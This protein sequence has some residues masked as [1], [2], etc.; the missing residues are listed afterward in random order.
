[1]ERRIKF[2]YGLT[3]C[4]IVAYTL[5][6]GYWLYSRYQLSL[7]EY[8]SELYDTII[9]CFEEDIAVRKALPSSPRLYGNRFRKA[10]NQK[11]DDKTEAWTCEIIAFDTLHHSLVIPK[12]VD[13]PTYLLEF[14]A[15]HGD[16]QQSE[17]PDG[18]ERFEFTCEN[19]EGVG[20]DLLLEALDRFIVDLQHPFQ[21]E[22]LDSI[23]RSRD[24]HDDLATVH[25]NRWLHLATLHACVVS[26]RHLRGAGGC[27]DNGHQYFASHPS[28]GL[29]ITNADIAIVH[30]YLLS[31]LSDTDYPKATAH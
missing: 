6:Q 7:D 2:I 18:M 12:D 3:I 1:M 26:L 29:Y 23:L 30:P 22:R 19:K 17:M 13:A 4:A 14:I 31:V 24:R 9:A 5:V 10:H 25:T 15:N 21:K 28:Y 27:G 8:K 11:D 16:T 20:T